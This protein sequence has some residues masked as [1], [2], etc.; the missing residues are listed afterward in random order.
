MVGFP[1]GH[2]CLRGKLF[3]RFWGAG[4]SWLLALEKFST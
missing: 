4:P 1:I 3:K 2:N